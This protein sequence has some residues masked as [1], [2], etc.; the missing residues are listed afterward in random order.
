FAGQ[1]PW[2]TRGELPGSRSSWVQ[3]IQDVPDQIGIVR[4]YVKWAYEVKTAANLRQV[5][6]RAH[7]IATA[8]PAGPVYVM[9]A[10]EPLAAPAAPSEASQRLGTGP[11]PGLPNDGAL[12]EVAL[13]LLEAERPLIVTSY[14]GRNPAAVEP[15]V[16]L[17][18]RLAIPVVES[19][20]FVLNFPRD[21]ELHLG[22]NP[23][24]LLAE[25]D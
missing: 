13:W 7:Q 20:A 18:E 11:A 25:A 22:V 8:E 21:H 12:R 2:T 5:V 15:L 1:S 19:S 9:A 3:T 17:A 10:R 6:E 4:Q 16:A 23:A 24:E 14:L